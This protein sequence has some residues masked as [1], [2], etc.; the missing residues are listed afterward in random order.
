MRN[1]VATTPIH[2]NRHDYSADQATTAAWTE[3]IA[4]MPV[5]ACAVEIFDSSGRILM[6]STGDA[7]SEDDATIPYFILPGG[8]SIFLP[9]EFGRGK[10]ISVKAVDADAATGSLVMNF[11]A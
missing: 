11:F 8:S 9:L 7:G 2:K 3:V 5:S 1:L 10:R 4:E 6:I